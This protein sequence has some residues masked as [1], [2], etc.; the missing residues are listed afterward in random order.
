M[1]KTKQTVRRAPA[2]N[3]RSSGILA[4]TPKQKH[5]VNV[6]QVKQEPVI[7]QPLSAP[8]LPVIVWRGV[9]EELKK[10]V[11][12]VEVEALRK[13]GEFDW[14]PLKD[15]L[16]TAI[17]GLPRFAISQLTTWSLPDTTTVGNEK[18]IVEYV[19]YLFLRHTFGGANLATPDRL[20]GI[21]HTHML[22]PVNYSAFCMSTF[23]VLL[24]HTVRTTP[25]TRKE[26]K[27]VHLY[28][29]FFGTPPC[30]LW[31][32][33]VV[34]MYSPFDS[35]TP[36]RENG[37]KSIFLECK[38]LTGQTQ[39]IRCYLSDTVRTLKL[40]LQE[41]TEIPYSQMRLMFAGREL[42]DCRED[43]DM[44]KRLC[45]YNLANGALLHVILR[46]RGC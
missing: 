13:A 23:G 2:S 1:A 21:W 18:A 25:T 42:A 6:A 46:L 9:R 26:M 20:D 36:E 5:S 45:D 38:L 10:T 3:V 12:D 16:S 31:N 30:E 22:M 37:Q 11:M 8:S 44:R 27:T 24:D 43:E 34:P 40:A 35:E 28:N 39:R 17:G 29:Q 7:S 32:F 19:R 41:S 15:E 4:E 14:Q 33:H